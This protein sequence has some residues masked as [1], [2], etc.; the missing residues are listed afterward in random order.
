MH[1]VD[2]RIS[3]VY[4]FALFMPDCGINKATSLRPAFY[5]KMLGVA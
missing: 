2:F 4:N 3:Y 5:L 1:D